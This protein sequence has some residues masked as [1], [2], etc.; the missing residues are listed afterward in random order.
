VSADYDAD[1]VRRE[2]LQR[3]INCVPVVGTAG[4]IIDVLLWEKMFAEEVSE[5]APLKSI[6]VPVVIMAGGKGTRLAPFTSVLPKPLIPLGEKTVIETIVDG[7]RA[8]GVDTFYLSVNYKSK[9]IKS[10]FEEL[11]PPY[12][13]NY[14]YEDQPLG[15][16]GSLY[17]LAGKIASDIVLTN[18]DVIIPAAYHELVSHRRSENNDITMVVSLRNYSIPYGICEIENGGRLKAI[19]EKPRYNFL[20]NTGLYVL[21]PHVLSMIPENEFFHITDLIEKL[22]LGG[23][24]VGVY[25]ISDKAWMDTGEWA[26]YRDAVAQLTADRRRQRRQPSDGD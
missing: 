26:Q 14:I 5:R 18:C 13:V 16:A 12:S 15:T 4:Q 3:N 8:Y 25:P 24:R 2:M 10:Y 19:R 21:K 1:V 22:R 7:F 23:G 20:V 6:N 17:A 9:I 11:E